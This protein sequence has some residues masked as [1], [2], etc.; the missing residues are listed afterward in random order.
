MAS[1][2]ALAQLSTKA[3]SRKWLCARLGAFRIASTTRCSAIARTVGESSTSD[4]RYLHA[5]T[6]GEV[7]RTLRWG[8]TAAG[9]YRSQSRCSALRLP[10]VCE[11]LCNPPQAGRC[12]RVRLR[13]RALMLTLALILHKRASKATPTPAPRTTTYHVPL[14]GTCEPADDHAD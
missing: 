9:D 3:A 13:R 11:L 8:C 10:H 6:R 1:Q 2:A 12:G 4:S 14:Q 7:T 5:Q